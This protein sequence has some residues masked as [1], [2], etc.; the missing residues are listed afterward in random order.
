MSNESKVIIVAAT[1]A[2]NANGKLGTAINK[3]LQGKRKPASEKLRDETYAE[4]LAGRK[5]RDLSDADRRI[6]DALKQGFSR[7]FKAKGWTSSKITGTKVSKP[8]ETNHAGIMAWIDAGLDS[9]QETEAAD[10]AV[11]KA[12][13]LLKEFKAK[14]NTLKMNSK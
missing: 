8:K 5:T 13:E 6:Y 1:E 2:G 9:V 12:I 7:A 14:F 3:A 4:H 11:D 10:F